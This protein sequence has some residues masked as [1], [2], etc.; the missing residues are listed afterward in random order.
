M[1]QTTP[2]ISIYI[3]AAGETNYDAAFAAGMVNIDQHDHSGGPTKGVPIS[4]TGIADGS[5]TFNKLAANV[6]DN[7]RGIGTNG[8]A[9]ANQLEL[10]GLAR[11]LFTIGGVAG[12]GFLVRNNTTA[13]TRTL[14]GTAH[15]IKVD[16][17]DGS[18]NPVFSLPADVINPL[19][20]AFLANAAVQA[21]VTGDGTNFVP[22]FTSTATGNTI[23]PLFNQGGNFNGSGTFIAPITGI[24]MVH[25]DLALSGI[26][27]SHTVAEIRIYINGFGVYSDF[28]GNLGAVRNVGNGFVISINQICK[29]TA[30]DQV[31]IQLTVSNGAQ[32]ITIDDGTFSAVLLC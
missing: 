15:Q 29:L 16:S 18:A 8:T 30:A 5:I 20:A 11:S 6:A 14:L 7:T 24:Y 17:G 22:V 2:N 12:T 19:Q 21:N 31:K 25:C 3:P 1:G 13:N 28:N 4:G 10:L 32:V 23:P 27:P 26:T 9:G